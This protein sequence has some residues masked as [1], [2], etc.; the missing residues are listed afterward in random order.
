MKALNF[1]SSKDF[2]PTDDELLQ[3]FLYNKINNK[4]IPDHL[5]ILEHDLFGTNQ[6]PLDIWNEFEASYSYGGKD[7]YFFTTL[8]KKS[9]TSTRSVRTIGNGNWE[10]EDTGKNIFAKDTNQLL[11]LKK[12]FR[13]EKSNTPQD[14]GWILHEYNLHKSLIN[15]T[16][17]NNYVLCRFR[18]NLKP[19]S[20]STQEKS[21]I[22]DQSNSYLRKTSRTKNCYAQEST[23]KT[24]IAK[25]GEPIIL[26]QESVTPKQVEPVISKHNVLVKK[27]TI[28][29]EAI[30]QSNN[31]GNKRKY[32]DNIEFGYKGRKRKC[33]STWLEEKRFIEQKAIFEYEYNNLLFGENI[34]QNPKNQ[35]D[36][37]NSKIEVVERTKK[38]ECSFNKEDDNDIIMNKEEEGEQE[39]IE[40][41]EDDDDEMSWPEFFAKNLLE[42]NG[43]EKIIKEDDVQMLDNSFHKDFLLGN[44]IM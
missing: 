18:K 13:F 20:Q 14:G 1:R 3:K 25:K 27:Y 41:E 30:T 19:E 40:E 35:V 22:A 26:K 38:R 10:G 39:E 31:G 8:K 36:S 11:G 7:L 28:Y 44:N 15:N 34:A 4:P 23:K 29:E 2:M 43:G 32:E 9:A 5:N 24:V 33:I 42:I 21:S 6:N 16:P 17:V 12:R 37:R